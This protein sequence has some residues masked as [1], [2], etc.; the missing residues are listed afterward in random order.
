M[1]MRSARP[2]DHVPGLFAPIESPSVD[3]ARAASLQVA[4][5]VPSAEVEE[6]LRMLGLVES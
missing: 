5:W 3:A 6:V 4:A 1:P 2:A